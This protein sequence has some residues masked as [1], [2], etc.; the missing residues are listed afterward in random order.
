MGGLDSAVSSTT[1]HLF[2]ESAWFR[3]EAISLRARAQ[4]LQTESSQRFERGVDP[5]VQQLAIH[6]ATAL[7]LD[8]I[9]GK[10]GP[11]VEQ[12]VRRYLPRLSPVT[13]RIAR[14]AQ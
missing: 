7:V 1:R 9:G 3:P 14:V 2:L 10:P 12:T 11:V 5:A 8:I 4:G 13:L 6:R